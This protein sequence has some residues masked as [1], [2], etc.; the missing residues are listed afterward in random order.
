MCSR[1][2]VNT[3]HLN[4][5]AASENDLRRVLATCSTKA[6]MSGVLNPPFQ[7]FLSLPKMSSVCHGS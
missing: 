7:Q 4:H 3:A 6:Y 1:M 2:I 5:L